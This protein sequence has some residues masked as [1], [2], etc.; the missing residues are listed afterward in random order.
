MEAQNQSPILPTSSVNTA[1]STGIVVKKYKNR[2]LYDTE[3]SRYI[4]L[5]DVLNIFQEGKEVQV[6][7]NATSQD[8][9]VSTL[10]EA[11]A[12]KS[13]GQSRNE[14][15]SALMKLANYLIK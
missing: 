13:K 11:L 2:K 7:D 3:S 5:E 6:I 14:T 4:K 8:I 12:K 10:L 15:A 1:L 9:T